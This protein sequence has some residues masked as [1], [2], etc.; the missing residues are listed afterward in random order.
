MAKLVMEI[1]T[2]SQ[3]STVSI[4]GTA[5]SNLSEVSVYNYSY[6]G[7]P[8]FSFSVLTHE[9]VGGVTKMTRLMASE[10]EAAKAAIANG[11]GKKSKDFPGLIEAP[12][13]TKAQEA[14]GD[15]WNRSKRV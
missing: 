10:S 6:D 11:T 13:K 4:D 8:K 15:L 1:D 7:E 12:G 14:F 3:E 2:E 5:V 9:K